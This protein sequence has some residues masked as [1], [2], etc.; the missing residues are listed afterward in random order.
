MALTKC[1][2][3]ILF[4][5]ISIVN[6]VNNVKFSFDSIEK[7]I[8]PPLLGREPRDCRA[9]ATVRGAQIR[10]NTIMCQN[11]LFIFLQIF[12]ISKISGWDVRSLQVR[13][14][15]LKNIFVPLEEASKFVLCD[16]NW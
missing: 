8:F 9:E 1:P 10:K 4:A 15:L 6:N 12:Y 5:A 13:A 2:K 3:E 14:I 16:Q 7:H 11:N